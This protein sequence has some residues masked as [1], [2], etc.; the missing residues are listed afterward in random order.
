MYQLGLMRKKW[1]SDEEI[2]ILKK[3]TTQVRNRITHLERQRRSQVRRCRLQV[4]L[5]TKKKECH[6]AWAEMQAV[7]LAE[8]RLLEQEAV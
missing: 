8:S 6:L 7:V 1:P 2:K 3:K 4:I 5:I